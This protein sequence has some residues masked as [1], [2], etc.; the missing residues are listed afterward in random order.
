MKT[1]EIE[2]AVRRDF[3]AD[4]KVLSIGPAGENLITYSCISTDQYH[5]AGRGG[6]GAVMGAKNLKAIAIRG[7]GS[8]AVG[9]ARAFLEDMRRIH[10]EYILT[11]DNLWA[12]E[13]G[14]PILV[15]V[16]NGGGALPHPP[17]LARARSRARRRSTRSRSRRSASRSAPATSAPSR[18]ATSMPCRDARGEGPE[19]ETIALGRRELRHR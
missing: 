19:Y 16:I 17:L 2:E 1:S 18:V 11:D 8:V 12:H 10:K 7:T 5:K 6:P 3:D 13:E 14:T 4:A 9:D 15:D